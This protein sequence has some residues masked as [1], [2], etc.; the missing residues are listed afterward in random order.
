MHSSVRTR[1]AGF[2]KDFE[3][4]ISWMYLDV[5]GLVTVG[6][7]NLIDPVSAAVGLPFVHKAS[8]AAAT[9]D[10][11]RAAWTALKA[12]TDL[13]KAGH[14]PCEALNDLRLTEASM[15]QLVATKLASNETFL[16]RT[17]PD[18][19][20]WPADAQLGVLSMAWA[21]GPGFP[22]NWKTFTA[23]VKAGDWAK[24]TANCKMNETGN[25]GLVP[26]NKA[27]ALLFSNAGVVAASGT[28]VSVL[29]FPQ[30]AVAP[31][32]P[33]STPVTDVDTTPIETPT[34]ETPV[35]E[36]PVDE[37]PVDETP[38]D[39]TP[40]DETPVDETPTEGQPTDENR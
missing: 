9:Q 34:D 25:A 20:A 38:T 13:A 30:T 10:E 26:R 27:N 39:E 29:H 11:I 3:A 16:K 19:D 35:D 2:S 28:D 1:F 37:T 32:V 31:V 33:V 21:M 12:R 36:T 24:A 17:F 23:A 8:G 15:D 14:R 7:G 5:K 40:T 22:A 6:V 18:F 4:R